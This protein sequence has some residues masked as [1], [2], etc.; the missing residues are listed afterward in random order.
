MF[1]IF[2]HYINFYLILYLILFGELFK[3]LS[4]FFIN[5]KFFQVFYEYIFAECIL[6]PKYWRCHCSKGFRR[7]SFMKFCQIQYIFIY[8]TPLITSILNLYKNFLLE[9]C[10]GDYTQI[11]L[12]LIIHLVWNFLT[13]SLDCCVISE[14]IYYYSTCSLTTIWMSMEC[15]LSSTVVIRIDLTS[16]A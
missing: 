10:L 11:I 5:L 6:E 12:F 8:F 7:K 3:F 4:K 16:P 1:E 2:K 9:G 14:L 15:Y 13:W